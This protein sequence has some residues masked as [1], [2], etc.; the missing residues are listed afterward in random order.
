LIALLFP[1]L[2]AA[3]L[4]PARAADL[5]EWLSA[6]AIVDQREAI[7]PGRRARPSGT[8]QSSLTLYGV[9]EPSLSES[10]SARIEA[11]GSVFRKS[12][13]KPGAWILRG[14]VKQANLAWRAPG[15][16]I[17]AGQLLTPWG[18][19]DAVNPTDFLVGKDYTFLSTREELRRLG[20]PGVRAS[21]VPDAGSSPIEATVVWH[22]RYAQS[23]LLIPTSG[24]PSGLAVETDPR[25]PRLFGDRQE[26]AAKL[27]YLSSSWDV[28]VSAFDGR[29]KFGQFVWDGSAVALRYLPVRAI[30]SD[31]SVAFDSF[32][33]KGESAYYFYDVGRHGLG[34]LSLTEPNH[35]ES[36][37]GVEKPFG[38]R[39]RALVQVLYRVHPSLRDSQTWVGASPVETAIVRGVARANALIQNYQD[40]SRVGATFLL[41]WTEEEGT[42]SAELGAVGNFVGGDYVVRPKVARK[43][44]ESFRASAGLDWYG[45]PVDRP[46]GALRDYRSVYA[47]AETSF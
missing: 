43:I 46:L 33:L 44:G 10:L 17:R 35:F 26:W 41:S 21:F 23:K 36:V 28:S 38:E 24:V 22:A 18:R 25:S 27:A 19:S 9:A 39:F 11:R 5:P 20:A 8:L 2:L 7:G 40:R 47:E 14:D 29:S 4:T 1:L 30:G 42:W 13:E 16:E 45:G 6:K 3:P 12:I 32:V 15:R 34:D 31:F 37:V